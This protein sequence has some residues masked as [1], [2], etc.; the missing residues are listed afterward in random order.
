MNSRDLLVARGGANRASKVP[1]DWK[2]RTRLVALTGF[3][4][5]DR[6]LIEAQLVRTRCKYV[7]FVSSDGRQ[8]A[9]RRPTC[10]PVLAQ[11][12]PR[13]KGTPAGGTLVPTAPSA[14]TM[15]AKDRRR[16]RAYLCLGRKKGH[17]TIRRFGT[18]GAASGAG[19]RPGLSGKGD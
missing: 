7:Q 1:A 16:E 14:R 10:G 2:T 18:C 15:P 12:P 13:T 19:G 4:P 9:Y 11:R 8:N 17:F 3:E 6:Q 5:A